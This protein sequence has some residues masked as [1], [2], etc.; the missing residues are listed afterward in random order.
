MAAVFSAQPVFLRGEVDPAVTDPFGLQRR[1]PA[2]LLLIQTADKQ[3]HLMVLFAQRGIH[4]LSALGT[5]A[6]TD[7]R[8]HRA[9]PQAA[10]F[11]TILTRCECRCPKPRSY[12]FTSPKGL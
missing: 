2:P 7:N 8:R 1:V 4:R 9:A 6:L 5:L 3:V 12:T 10:G 11:A